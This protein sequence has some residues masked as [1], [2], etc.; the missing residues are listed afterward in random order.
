M[1]AREQF[2]PIVY[3]RIHDGEPFWLSTCGIPVFDERGTLVTYRGVA[4]NISSEVL[5]R[6]RL[7]KCQAQA[8]QTMEILGATID[9]FPEPVSVFDA[10]LKLVV[11]N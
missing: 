2:G 3:Q 8:D 4:Y 11:A 6:E 7:S 5:Q 1:K 9:C 10:K